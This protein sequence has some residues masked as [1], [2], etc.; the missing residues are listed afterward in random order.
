MEACIE[1]SR[2]IAHRIYFAARVDDAKV[3]FEISDTGPGIEREEAGKI[4]Q[5]FSSSKGKRGTGIGLFVTRKAI[6]KHGGTITVESTPNEGAK[7]S[8]TLPRKP[9]AHD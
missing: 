6:L 1:D 2:D 7:F 3:Y 8:I 9:K 5:L 4:F